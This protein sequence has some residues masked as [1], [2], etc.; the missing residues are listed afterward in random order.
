MMRKQEDKTDNQ[1]TDI[2]V[3]RQTDRQVSLSIVNTDDTQTEGV[4]L[5]LMML[6][7]NIRTCF[8][9]I[10]CFALDISISK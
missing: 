8:W 2:D 9:F 7:T 5:Q 3:D 1:V 10:I 4:G 6:M